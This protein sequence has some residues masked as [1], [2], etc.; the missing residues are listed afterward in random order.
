[1]TIN[2]RNFLYLIG[3]ATGTTVLGISNQNRSVFA[4]DEPTYSGPFTVPP[5]PYPYEALEPY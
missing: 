2:R 5:L 4:Q 3:A 1:M